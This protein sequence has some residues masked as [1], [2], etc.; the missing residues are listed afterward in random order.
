MKLKYSGM[1][2]KI[3]QYEELINEKNRKNLWSL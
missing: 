2:K 1:I 3:K